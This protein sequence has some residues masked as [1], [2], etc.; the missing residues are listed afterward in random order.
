[1][2]AK[3]SRHSNHR[4][5]DVAT[6]VAALAW[7]PGAWGHSFDVDTRIDAGRAFL[8]MSADEQRTAR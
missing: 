6:S 1:M 8:A 7:S 2:N 3:K 4:V 5:Q